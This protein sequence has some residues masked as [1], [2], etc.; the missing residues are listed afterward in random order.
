MRDTMGANM[1]RKTAIAYCAPCN[2][3]PYALRI[4]APYALAHRGYHQNPVFARQ[5]QVHHFV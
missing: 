1:R 5:F 2:I 3:A 4:I